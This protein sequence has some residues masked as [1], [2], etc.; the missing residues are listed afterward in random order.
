MTLIANPPDLPIPLRMDEYGK[1][2]VGD[3]RVLLELVIRAFYNGETPEGIV[4]SYPAL[5]IAD[6]YAVI[7]YYL[8]YP[9]EIDAYL[10]DVDRRTEEILQELKEN[11]SPETRALYARLGA[12]KEQ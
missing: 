12:H 8:T 11:Q 10:R 2:R 7:A 3:S 6:V 9:E 4:E 1:F 5:K